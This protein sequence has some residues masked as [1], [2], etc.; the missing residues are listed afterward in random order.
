[1]LVTADAGRQ[2]I[3]PLTGMP[4][5]GTRRM[6]LQLRLLGFEQRAVVSCY[7]IQQRQIEA[8]GNVTADPFGERMTFAVAAADDRPQAVVAGEYC[9]AACHAFPGCTM[10]PGTAQAIVASVCQALAIGRS[11]AVVCRMLLMQ[12]IA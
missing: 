9:G 11:K 4:Q 10:F 2:H 1:M 12:A 8:D 5:T 7:G 6:L 3:E